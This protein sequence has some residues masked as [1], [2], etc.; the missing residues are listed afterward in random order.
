M[1]AG[2]KH[3]LVPA[4]RLTRVSSEIGGRLVGDPAKFVDDAY[5]VAQTLVD[6]HREFTQRLIELLDT[7]PAENMG[8]PDQVSGLVLPFPTRLAKTAR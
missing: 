1:A 3:P 7:G 5:T 4:E 6:L 8:S 2:R